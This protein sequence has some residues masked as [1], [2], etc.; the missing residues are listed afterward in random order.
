[1]LILSVIPATSGEARIERLPAGPGPVSAPLEHPHHVAGRELPGEEWPRVRHPPRV[2]SCRSY[3]PGDPL[4]TVGGPEEP[5]SVKTAQRTSPARDGSSRTDRRPGIS[6]GR[7]D[8]DLFERGGCDDLAGGTA[9]HGQPASQAE[10]R[11]PRQPDGERG[12]IDQCLLG[13]LLQCGREVG[14]VAV[15]RILNLTRRAGEADEVD[16]DL[17]GS[18]PY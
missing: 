4:D 7:W 12:Q 3:R 5:G 11:L 8:E 18:G 14:V 15:Q 10:P 13:A 2:K 6:G 16:G 1:V 9:V 17:G